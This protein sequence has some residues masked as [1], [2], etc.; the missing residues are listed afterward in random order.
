MYVLLLVL[1]VTALAAWALASLKTSRPDGVLLKVHPFRRMMTFIMRGRNESVVYFDDYIDVE[2]LRAYLVQARERFP[3]D[4]THCVVAGVA[5][6][7]ATAPKMN[8]F[9]VGHRLYQRD[10]RWIT[11]SMKR[12][13]MDRE[14]KLA[15]V[16][17]DMPDGQTFR[18]LA[19]RIDG[20]VLI[21]RSDKKTG[22]DWEMSLLNA[23]PRPA[24]RLAV[25]LWKVADYYNLLPAALIRSDAMYTSVFVANLGSLKMGAGYHH[26]YEWGTCSTFVMVG[27]I[28][29]HP[30]VRDGQVVVRERVHVRFSFDER[31]DDGLNARF[32]I[33]TLRAVLED[34]FTY[35]GCLA[36]DGSDARPLS[37]PVQS[38]LPLTPE[39]SQAS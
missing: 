8:R 9:V 25:G 32:G 1:A 31:I 21:E 22:F 3:V 35:L 36:E 28:E 30:V 10:R 27:Q 38:V 2:Q 37:E 11:F 5:L 29:E 24:L 23:L 15:A 4:I 18:E 7:L 14:A 19:E 13:K 39:A 33:D 12:K 17:L 16:K 34:P 26:L 6:G 20:K